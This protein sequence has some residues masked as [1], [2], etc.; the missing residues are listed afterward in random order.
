[1]GILYNYIDYENIENPVQTVYQPKYFYRLWP[2]KFT[3]HKFYFQKHG[4]TDNT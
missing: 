4:F 3:T 1:M 2:Y